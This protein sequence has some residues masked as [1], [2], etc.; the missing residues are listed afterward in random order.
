MVALKVGPGRHARDD[1]EHEV[2]D[3]RAAGAGLATGE[4]VIK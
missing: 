1:G 2:E 3:E 4:S